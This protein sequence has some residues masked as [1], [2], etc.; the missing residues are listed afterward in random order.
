MSNESQLKILYCGETKFE[1]NNQFKLF[2]QT[3]F[4]GQTN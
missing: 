4:I 1:I 3:L 2:W